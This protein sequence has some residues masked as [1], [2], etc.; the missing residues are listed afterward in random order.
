MTSLTGMNIASM[1]SGGQQEQGHGQPSRGVQ[2]EQQGEAEDS[3]PVWKEMPKP[4]FP[5]RDTCNNPMQ[6]NK[7][8]HKTQVMDCVKLV[9]SIVQTRVSCAD[10]TLAW[11]QN[12][13]Y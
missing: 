6:C 1:L 10:R 12:D 3:S 4:H 5:A 11:K 2:G 7:H 8:I 9:S 13:R